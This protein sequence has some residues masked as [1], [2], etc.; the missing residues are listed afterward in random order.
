[1]QVIKNTLG[2]TGRRKRRQWERGLRRTKY[3]EVCDK[4]IAL[5]ANLI[6]IV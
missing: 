3:N 2:L 6:K 5:C 4:P 1:M